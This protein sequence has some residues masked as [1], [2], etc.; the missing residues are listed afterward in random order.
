MKSIE[1]L[2]KKI[3]TFSTT[4]Q[5]EAMMSEI[6]DEIETEIAEGYMRLPRDVDGEPINVGDRITLPRGEETTVQFVAPDCVLPASPVS[7]YMAV[8]CRRVK[9]DPLKELLS[10][11]ALAIIDVG[12]QNVPTIGNVPKTSVDELRLDEWIEENER[13]IRKVMG[14]DAR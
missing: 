10:E 7:Y 9:T 4:K 11:A 13:R 5:R 12:Y 14:A 3:S 6:V 1:K 2:R 8:G